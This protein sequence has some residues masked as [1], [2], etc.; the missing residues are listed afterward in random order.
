M[1]S[2]NFKYNGWRKIYH[3]AT[4]QNK[5]GGALLTSDTAAFRSREVMRDKEGP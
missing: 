2:T 5:A 4:N 3:A 1:L